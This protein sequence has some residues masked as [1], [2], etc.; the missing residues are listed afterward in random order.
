MWKDPE[1]RGWGSVL[2]RAA[3]FNLMNIQISVKAVSLWAPSMHMGE[4]P[5]VGCTLPVLWS[6]VS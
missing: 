1:S 4:I 2:I 5:W 6:H 3:R